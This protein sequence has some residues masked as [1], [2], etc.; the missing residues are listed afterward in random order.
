M[1]KKK[2]QQDKQSIYGIL[3]YT[4]HGEIMVS[5]NP[6]FA[7]ITREGTIWFAERIVMPEGLV[8][9]LHAQG[10]AHE[11]GEYGW[12]LITATT[13]YQYWYTVPESVIEVVE[14]ELA[15]TSGKSRTAILVE[16]AIIGQS[17]VAEH[18]RRM[19]HR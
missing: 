18:E 15:D 1:S 5:E 17:Q 6:M 11:D 4:P 13:D 14:M 10:F 2:E 3:Q 9:A 12:R 19:V 16:C 7:C 8:A